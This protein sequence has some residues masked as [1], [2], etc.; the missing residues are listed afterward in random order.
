ML[1]PSDRIERIPVPVAL[2]HTELVIAHRR[3]IGRN[4]RLYP[5]SQFV[6]ESAVTN[7]LVHH[8]C[9]VLAAASKPR[10]VSNSHFFRFFDELYDEFLL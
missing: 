3:L 10:I 1:F 6:P 4:Q 5:A 8:G 2:K 7:Q 9:N